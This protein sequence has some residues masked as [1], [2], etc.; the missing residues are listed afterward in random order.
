MSLSLLVTGLSGCDADKW[1]TTDGDRT[2]PAETST[3]PPVN[4]PVQQ[5]TTAAEPVTEEE[6]VTI[7]P[8]RIRAENGLV[9]DVVA[10]ELKGS[11]VAQNTAFR[12]V[13]N[14]GVSEEQLRKRITT[15]PE[16]DFIIT[17][18]NENSCILSTK[19]DL[20]EGTVVRVEV[21]DE[22][23]NPCDSWAF[24]TTEPFKVKS[25]YPA[26]DAESV[27]SNAGIEI[28][29]TAPP[30]ANAADF[31]EISPNTAY[32]AQFHR[33]TLYLIPTEGLEQGTEYNV[34]V[35]KELSSQDGGF[36]PE[37]YSFSFVTAQVESKDYFYTN[38][39]LSETFLEGDPAVIEIYCSKTLGTREFDISLYS[40]DSAEDYTAELKAHTNKKK[41]VKYY[42]DVS[43][44]TQVMSEKQKPLEGFNEWRPR[45]FVLPDDLANGYYI[46]DMSVGEL[47]CQYL[48]Q[49]SPISVYAMRLGEENLFFVNDT[50]TG[51]A[52]S[53]AQIAFITEN[54]SFTGRADSDGTLNLVAPQGEKGILD[55]TYDGMRYIDVFSTYATEEA[56][57]DD[58]YYMYIYTDRETY[59]PS[60]TIQ[61]WG[62]VAP[63]RDDAPIPTDLKLVLGSETG[64]QSKEI[65][66]D[67]DGTFFSEFTFTDYAETWGLYL[68]LMTGDEVMDEKGVRILEYIKPTY[69]FDVTLP[70]YAVMPHREAVRMD[71]TAS[72]YEGTPAKDLL[73]DSSAKKAEPAVI[74]TDVNGCASAELL[75]RDYDSWYPDYTTHKL[76]LSGIENEY[77]YEYDHF[78]G[79]YRDVML[80]HEYDKDTCNFTVYTNKMDFNKIPEY[81]AQEKDV[82]R[83]FGIGGYDILKG[84]AY[85]TEVKIEITHY[86]SERVESGTYYDFIEK[87]TRKTYKYIDH[88]DFIGNFTVNTVNGVGV[89]EN[90]PTASEKGYYSVDISY[91]DS[92]GQTVKM[93][94]SFGNYDYAWYYTEAKRYF[95]SFD[96]VNS[97]G[98][99]TSGFHENETLAVNLACNHKFEDKGR[100]MFAAYQ[101]DI[102]DFDVYEGTS[103]KY[104]PSLDCL[105]NFRAQGAYFDGRHIYPVSAGYLKFDPSERNITLSVETDAETYDAGETVQMTVTAKDKDGNPVSGAAVMLSVV[106]EAAFAAGEQYVDTLS[107]IYESVWYAYASPY[108]SY[109]QHVLD[110]E[111]GGEK[112]GG[113]DDGLRKDFRDNAY[114]DSLMTDAEGNAKFVFKLPDNLTTWRATIQS[115][116]SYETGRVLAGNL[117]HPIISTRPVFITPIML[118]EFMEGDDIAVTAKAHGIDPDDPISVTIEGGDVVKSVSVLSAQTANFGKLSAGEYKVTFETEN[119]GFRD[120]VQLPLTVTDT[121]IQTD[122]YSKGDLEENFDINPVSWPVNVSFVNKEYIFIT[123]VLRRFSRMGG[124][125][126]ATRV[127][128]SF[129]D[130][131]LGYITEEEF[132]DYFLH[133]TAEDLAKPLP[134]AGRDLTL[135]VMLCAAVPEIINKGTIVPILEDIISDRSSVKADV[136]KAYL[137]LAALGEPVLGE[138]RSL[139]Q[140]GQITDYYQQIYLASALAILGDYDT[141]YGI[142]EKCVPEVAVYGD[143]EMTCAYVNCPDESQRAEYTKAALMAASLMKLPEADYF[144]RG[145]SHLRYERQFESYAPEMI[146]YIKNFVPRSGGE[147]VF[148]YKLNGE[149]QTITL[150]R[151][152]VYRMQFGEEQWKN[153]DF[154]VVSGEIYTSVDYVGRPDEIKDPKTL[155]VTKT[156]S[157]DF[158]PGGLVRVTINAPAFCVIDDVV[159][160]CGRYVDLNSQGSRSGQKVRLWTGDSTS[161]S[162]YFRIVTEGEY[163]V[164]SAVAQYWGGAW[165]ESGRKTIT[166]TSDEAV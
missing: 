154:K 135:T 156:I 55:I 14:D 13:L 20:P 82:D 140:S 85:D 101:N 160:S 122:I 136:C 9:T 27:Y 92:L 29:F 31:V 39:G 120:A 130:M 144:A 41:N 139:A 2:M 106:D 125:N 141:A 153:A 40:F 46:A 59:L 32:N 23:G 134:A 10:T 146:I 12:L 118:S 128:N 99:S 60:D 145:L 69:T 54:G 43:A 157:G 65:A 90:L 83:Y 34:T 42:T 149:T 115:V 164:E 91:K 119:N 151:H 19:E 158:Y 159:P 5:T 84:A 94:T 74:K 133:E 143:D 77:N 148:S 152:R 95:Y 107:D 100:I 22:N 25:T 102:L 4:L 66:L 26:D 28:E 18:E 37:D 86:Y 50:T 8:D 57:F 89:F 93:Y 132:R 36:L 162:Y 17:R 98:E 3:T 7:L 97:E 81:L 96:F 78:I 33:N 62:V 45:Y 56:G 142:Y 52:A 113:G 70:Q 116:K 161:V 137:G 127:G 165:G 108:Y 49:V 109:I 163:V 53:G 35:K 48:I 58:L 129:A 104:S 30:S 47:R 124:K 155:K 75:F 131:E 126:L 51:N 111:S 67:K 80:E 88:R 63:R 112:G 6:K 21:A 72:Y 105:P 87:E 114:F 123:D 24:Q 68:R 15:Y 138:V 121:I 117:K 79:F 73:F 166:V 11:C 147:A 71:V 1:D 103:F 38:Y 16:A 44:L 76:Q 150:D 110:S 64:G 61:V